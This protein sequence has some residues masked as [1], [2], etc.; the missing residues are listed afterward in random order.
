MTMTCMLMFDVN[1]VIQY[2]TL[3]MSRSS[4]KIR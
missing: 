4:R 1:L 2:D 3:M